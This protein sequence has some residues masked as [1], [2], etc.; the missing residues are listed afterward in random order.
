MVRQPRFAMSFGM[1][2]FSASACLSLAGVKLS[3]V[4]RADLRPAA[5]RRNYY[6]TSGRVKKYYDN[7]RFVYELESRVREFKRATTPVEPAPEDNHNQKE[8]PKDNTSGEPQHI[9]PEQ[10]QERNYSQSADQPI[11]A[12]APDLTPVVVPVTTYRRFS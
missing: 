1:I 10:P 12:A 5:I 8:K 4:R 6:E 11:M 9:R 7:L 2:F 3:D